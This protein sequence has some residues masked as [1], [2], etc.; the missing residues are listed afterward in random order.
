MTIQNS[1][2][3]YELYF[4]S[5]WNLLEV[6]PYGPQKELLKCPSSVVVPSLYCMDFIGY[7]ELFQVGSNSMCTN[8]IVSGPNKGYIPFCAPME[9]GYSNV[10]T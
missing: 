10:C 5:L 4:F 8:N 3:F 9:N 7:R 2:L 1:Y 6:I